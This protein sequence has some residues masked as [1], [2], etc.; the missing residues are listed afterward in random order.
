MPK[1][2]RIAPEIFRTIRIFNHEDQA[3]E[4]RRDA[5]VSPSQTQSVGSKEKCRDQ[6]IYHIKKQK[7]LRRVAKPLKY[8]EK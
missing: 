5:L 7:R 8:R 3:M 6:R 4:S 2:M 1:S